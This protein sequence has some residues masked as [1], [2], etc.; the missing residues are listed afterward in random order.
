M[1][2]SWKPIR[3]GRACGGKPHSW[4][5]ASHAPTPLFPGRLHC[6]KSHRLVLDVF[7][8][9]SAFAIQKCWMFLPRSF[10]SDSLTGEDSLLDYSILSNPAADLLD[11]FA[12]V[13]LSAPTSAG[14]TWN[15]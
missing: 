14:N 9:Y 2:G 10:H 12:P 5:G 6:F 8:E 1:K 7:V 13:T 15:R 11:E 4:A 3:Q